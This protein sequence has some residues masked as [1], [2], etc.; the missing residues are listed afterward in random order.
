[1]KII[2]KAKLKKR[3]L[4]VNKQNQF[5]QIEKEV[6]IM[7][8]MGHPYIVK[9]VEIIDDPNHHKQYLICEYVQKGSL[10]GKIN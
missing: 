7:K 6:A 8:K 10:L 2:N 4:S 1:M 9:L 3:I 5:N